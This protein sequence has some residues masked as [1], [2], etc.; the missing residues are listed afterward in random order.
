VVPTSLQ[1]GSLCLG[2]VSSFLEQGEYKE[3]SRELQQP[4]QVKRKIMN[5]EITFDVYD[6]VQNFS[7]SKWKR[8]VAVVCSGHEWQ[9][10]GWKPMQGSG[11]DLSK[12]ELFARVRGYYMGFSDQKPP[13]QVQ[14]WNV[15]KLQLPRNQRHHDVNEMTKFWLDLEQFMKREKFK[16]SDW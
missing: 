4:V 1:P 14:L 2:N 6:S 5:K 10:K 16:G 15:L 3:T 7:D 8:L 12:R 11:S 13:A 9:F